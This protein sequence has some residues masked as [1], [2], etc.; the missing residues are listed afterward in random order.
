MSDISSGQPAANTVQAAA[1]SATQESN[2]A[3]A[4]PENVQ[5]VVPENNNVNGQDG[6]IGSQSSLTAD[7]SK[8]LQSQ[9][10]DLAKF[11]IDQSNHEAVDNFINLHKSMRQAR[12][13]NEQVSQQVASTPATP[14]NL[15]VTNQTQTTQTLPTQGQVQNQV[16]VSPQMGPSQLD[17]VNMK[18]ILDNTYT[19][20]KDK[21]G[22][23]EFYDGMQQMGFSPVSA[24][25]Q[26]NVSQIMRYADILNTKAENERLK[27]QL[28]RPNAALVPDTSDRVDVSLN[29]LQVNGASMTMNQAENILIS[30]NQAASRGQTL[31]ADDQA[32]VVQATKV[33]QG[34]K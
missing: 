8:Y 4:A 18:M 1:P 23:K 11:G 15:L 32:L 16:Q 29:S 7:E 25:G 10:L 12:S 34:R 14:E 2:V 13:R 22:T 27:A 3:L 26:F 30:A 21:V 9:N 19:N 20:I 17:I 5:N 24:N 6:Q 33:L 31:S 28:N